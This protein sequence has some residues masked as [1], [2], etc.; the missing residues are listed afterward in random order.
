ML[1]EDAQATGGRA[2]AA[3]SEARTTANEIARAAIDDTMAAHDLDAIVGP[4]NGV[5][6]P[7]DPVNGDL[8]GDFSTFVGSSS[9]SAI[10]GY[11]SAAAGANPSCSAS[12]MRSSR[13]RRSASRRSSS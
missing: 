7:T 9:P 11:P 8:G 6:W 12:R 4:T 3:C 2:D 13:R 10:S 1:F 5:A